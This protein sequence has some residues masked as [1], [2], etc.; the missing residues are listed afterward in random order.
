MTPTQLRPALSDMVRSH[1]GTGAIAAF[2]WDDT[3]TVG[4]I[5]L[6]CL[7][8]LDAENNTHVLDRYNW[9]CANVS[10][11]VGYRYCTNTHAGRTDAELNALAERVWHAATQDGRIRPRTWIQELMRDMLANDWQVWVVTANPRSIVQIAAATYGIPRSNVIGMELKTGPDGRLLPVLVQP[12]PYLD[13]KVQALLA[14]VG[15]NP[16]FAASD[17]ISDL[18]LLESAE[19]SLALP[20]WNDGLREQAVQ[21]GWWVVDDR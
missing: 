4:D 20:A 2:D 10:K 8:T 9:M 21:R 18:A 5:G 7:A 16:T 6:T 12:A 13:Q 17:S 19:Y 15:R 14:A 3:C 11:H 1:A